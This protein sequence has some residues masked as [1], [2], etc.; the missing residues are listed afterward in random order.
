MKHKI[1]LRRLLLCLIDEFYYHLKHYWNNSRDDLQKFVLI[2]NKW[3][4]SY[5]IIMWTTNLQ[6]RMSY[7]RNACKWIWTHIR[8]IY[9]SIYFFW[10][11]NWT[12]Q[13]VSRFMHAFQIF[14]HI[15]KRNFIYF[16]FSFIAAFLTGYLPM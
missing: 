11:T 4:I 15:L 1:C 5:Q 3:C 7:I 2:I 10:L 14:R 12:F 13:D 16:E 8:R 9:I 6:I